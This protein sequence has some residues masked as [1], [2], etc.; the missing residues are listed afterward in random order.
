MLITLIIMLLEHEI[1]HIRMI[2]EEPYD[3]EDCI[4]TVAA[5]IQL[6]LQDVNYILKYFRFFLIV[7]IFTTLLLCSLINKCSLD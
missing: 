7:I 1:K 5:E 3:T 4:N 2:S 6:S